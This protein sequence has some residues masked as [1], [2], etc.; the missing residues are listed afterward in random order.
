MAVGQPWDTSVHL[1]RAPYLSVDVSTV[2]VTSTVQVCNNGTATWTVTPT[3]TASATTVSA[4]STA[5]TSASSTSSSASSSSAGTT[6]CTNTT[7]T[8]QDVRLSNYPPSSAW[9]LVTTLTD[10][11]AQSSTGQL[12]NGTGTSSPLTL[13]GYDVHF[14]A[15]GDWL[16]IG[17]PGRSF[18]NFTSLP[19]RNIAWHPYH[20]SVVLYKIDAAGTATLH[21]QLDLTRISGMS[22]RYFDRFGSKLRF[23]PDTTNPFLFVSSNGAWDGVSAPGGVKSNGNPPQYGA[24]VAA[25][26]WPLLPTS[27]TTNLGVAV[28]RLTSASDTWQGVSFLGAQSPVPLGTIGIDFAVAGTGALDT[29]LAVRDY[30]VDTATNSSSGIVTLYRQN[31]NTFTRVTQVVGSE[32][33]FPSTW[34]NE[35]W[36]GLGLALGIDASSKMGVLHVGA[37]R[38]AAKV[39]RM[40]SNKFGVWDAWTADG[41]VAN[42]VRRD[43]SFFGG[44]MASTPDGRA[45]WIA[46]AAG[47]TGRGAVYLMHRR[48]AGM[49][50][51]G[52]E[53]VIRESTN[54]TVPMDWLGTLVTSS[55]ASTVASTYAADHFGKAIATSGNLVV[56]GAPAGD[57]VYTYSLPVAYQIPGWVS[58]VVL[59][60]NTI[61]QQPQPTIPGDGKGRVSE[62]QTTMYAI[63]GSVA[64]I[65]VMVPAALY[66]AMHFHKK[67]LIAALEKSAAV[68][69][70]QSGAPL[71]G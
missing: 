14:S 19:L 46:D 51:Y 67:R 31:I 22:R 68:A 57:C 44:S 70:G 17:V 71:T 7:T 27:S 6:S 60:N 15:A 58:N 2:N 13:F 45:T 3:S 5:A 64:G 4:T 53:D 33:G 23:S 16:A 56:V 32:V 29:L 26:Q 40:I 39:L 49:Q 69:A 52:F 62:D 63:I 66:V 42:P 54:A 55:N 36:F 20:G 35:D 25:G 12:W 65:V 61:T 41:T 34:T 9:T 43:H 11:F 48:V 10:P 37:P 18:T 38:L 47:L 30:R 28:F 24:D 1:Y 8:T 21:S 50:V 59:P